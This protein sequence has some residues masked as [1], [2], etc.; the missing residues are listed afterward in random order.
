[1]FFMITN[2]YN[3]TTKRPNLMELF[4]AT[5]K[6]RKYFLIT[7][8]FRCV[9]HG[10]H[11]THRNDIQVLATHASAWV[12]RYSSLLLGTDHYSSEEYRC[13]HV[14]ACVART[15][16]LYRCVPCHTWCTH[17]TSLVTQILFQF[18]CGCEQFH[19][20]RFFDFLVLKVCIHGEHYETPCIKYL[21][22]KW[23]VKLKKTCVPV[24]DCNAPVH[25]TDKMYTFNLN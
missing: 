13:T 14:N 17:R 16:I 24:G 25:C 12:H 10:R 20:G 18:S 23:T 1:M 19:W 22:L 3:K 6:L 8:Y 2:I 4:T 9:Q 7:R 5:G 11:G 21:Q 15:W